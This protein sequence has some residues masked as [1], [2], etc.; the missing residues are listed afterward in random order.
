MQQVAYLPPGGS[1]TLPVLDDATD[2]SGNVLVVQSV[3]TPPDSAVQTGIVQNQSV[4]LTANGQL[5]S[6]VDLTYTISDGTNTSTAGIEVLPALND[7]ADLPPVAEPVTAIV[8]EGDVAVIN[9]LPSDFG[10]EGAT[11]QLAPGT[12]R[13]N[14]QTSHFSDAADIGSAFVDGSTIRYLAPVQTG[15]AQLLYGITDGSGQVVT[16]TVTV[17]VLP[18]T[19]V[20][21]APA[22]EPLEASVIA[23]STVAV[24][25]PMDGVDPNGESVEFLGLASGPQ[26][27]EVVSSSSDSFTYEAYPN[28]SGT[29]TFT[30]AMRNRSGINGDGTVRIGIAPPPAIDNPPIAVAQNV[31]M[32]PGSTM[33]FPV[34]S[35]DFDPQGYPIEFAPGSAVAVPNSS[36]LRATEIGADIAVSAPSAGVSDSTVRYEI[37]DGHSAVVNGT[38]TVTTI[39]GYVETPILQDMTVPYLSNPNAS[40]V[41]V[42]PLASAI[43]PDGSPSDLKIVS[44][45]GYDTAKPP[46]DPNGV[47][48]IHLVHT[49]QVIVYTV[50]GIDPGPSGESSATITVPPLGFTGPQLRDPVPSIT[51]PENKSVAIS[52]DKYLIDPSGKA[53]RLTSS[54]DL[55]GADG[56]TVADSPS[57]FTFTPIQGY[58]G[59][60]AVTF[61]VTDV[62]PGPADTAPPRTFTLHITVTG[63]NAPPIFYGPV[64]SAVVGEH[65]S[66]NLSK[67]I[68]D[69]NPGGSGSVGL[70]FTSPPV[71][72]LG[73]SLSGQTLTLSPQNDEGDVAIL[74]LNLKDSH[75]ATA[76]GAVQI[77]V[78]AT[79]RPLAVAV[80]QNASVD[81]GKSVSVDV[82]SADVNPYPS[83]EPL[84]VLNASSLTAAPPG[85]D[86]RY[87]HHIH[88]D[89]F[90]SGTATG[91]L[92]VAGQSTAPSREVHGTMTIAVYG[93]PGRPGAPNVVGYSSG[94]VLLFHGTHRLTMGRP[95]T[96]T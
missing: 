41:Q 19:P 60:A 59:P 12:V 57:Q 74:N 28:S 48:T 27:G 10:P 75:G 76:K 50:S 72:N 30:Y 8:H 29:D 71:G 32:R 3:S 56:S 20:T 34:L 13:V 26:K 78:V 86:Q 94:T 33:L 44:F 91:R 58:V 43:D 23:G 4:R 17:Q 37:T 21:Q 81:Q 39:P 16:S 2:P 79:N 18:A 66:F 42:N 61:D 73:A 35:K 52:I 15:V 55:S 90:L 6:P 47:V 49:T 7:S 70:S 69:T 85:R 80:P 87:E 53:M 67:Y 64:L 14:A 31:D 1:T 25:V 46:S 45:A 68:K 96:T 9:P 84:K 40:V 22:P 62:A 83:S 82:L 11:L 36:G 24:N 51:T 95:S 88:R 63:D 93:V 5:G 65:S 38:L 77:D 89:I 92:H 54:S